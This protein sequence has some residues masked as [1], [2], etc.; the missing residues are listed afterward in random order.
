MRL[1]ASVIKAGKNL[2]DSDQMHSMRAVPAK[3]CRFVPRARAQT[4]R[5]RLVFWKYYFCSSSKLTVA[6]H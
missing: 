1:V 3:N 5:D 4:D 2:T 6:E